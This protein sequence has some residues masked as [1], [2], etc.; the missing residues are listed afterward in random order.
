MKLELPYPPSANRNWL[1]SRQGGVYLSPATLEFRQQIAYL[2]ARLQPYAGPVLLRI[3]AYPPRTNCDLD[4]LLKV[5]CDALNGFAWY[6]D[7]QIHRIE[8]TRHHATKAT[9]RV[10]VEVEP[11]VA[12]LSRST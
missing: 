1:H 9:A 6:D 4:N 10:I 3:D 5:L 7:K 11:Y 8:V 12:N 2:C